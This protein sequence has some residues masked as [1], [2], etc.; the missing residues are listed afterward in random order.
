MEDKRIWVKDFSGKH[1]H[2]PEEIADM[3]FLAAGKRSMIANR[4]IPSVEERITES[5]HIFKY[6]PAQDFV[7]PES[8]RHGEYIKTVSRELTD[9]ERSKIVESLF[10][11]HQGE[12]LRLRKKS[13]AIKTSLKLKRAKKKVTKKSNK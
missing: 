4:E 7:L 3:M 1:N 5:G 10:N 9:A 13:G 6:R 12:I 2:S 11:M 8:T